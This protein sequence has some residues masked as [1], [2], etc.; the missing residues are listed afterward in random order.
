MLNKKGGVIKLPILGELADYV[1][2]ATTCM[3]DTEIL[4]KTGLS[5]ASWRR[6]WRGE[7]ISEPLLTQFAYGMGLN[8]DEIL[9]IARKVRP[10]INPSKFIEYALS[11]SPLDQ[12]S[13]MEVMRLYKKLERE[14]KEKQEQE[15][16][17]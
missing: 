11:I 3:T 16:A 13:K 6:L 15:S 7:V 5:F 9:D 10:T 8:P 2:S 17:A 1:Q 14:S 4:K 12:A